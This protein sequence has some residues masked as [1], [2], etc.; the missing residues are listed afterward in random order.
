MDFKKKL[1]EVKEI[2]HSKE[3]IDINNI[4]KAIKQKYKDEL[5]NFDYVKKP[6][7]L[8]KYKNK[9]I[10]YVGYDYKLHYGGFL[11]KAEKIKKDIFIYLINK[12]KKVWIIN[13]S[14]YY[15]FINDVISSRD[16]HLR[17]EFIKYLLTQEN[18]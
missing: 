7:D 8:L 15:I 3:Y 16:N 2:L 4:I 11:I 9:Y 10:R 12:D 13:S 5:M 18:N 1:A 14:R 6:S 17:N